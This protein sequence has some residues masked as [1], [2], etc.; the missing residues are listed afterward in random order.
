MPNSVLVAK[1]DHF[2]IISLSPLSA[3]DHPIRLD[4]SITRERRIEDSRTI[5]DY[6]CISA[7]SLSRAGCH[8]FELC[9]EVEK[10]PCALL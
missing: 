7:P 5:I 8:S 3:L 10:P 4:T 9:S 6:H 2:H 1:S